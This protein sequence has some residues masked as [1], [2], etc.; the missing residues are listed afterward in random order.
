MSSACVLGKGSANAGSIYLAVPAWGPVH[1]FS[2]LY[3]S[4]CLYK[5]ICRLC[6]HVQLH[7]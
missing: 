7:V 6:I 1:V 4:L 2:L 5:Y 3:S